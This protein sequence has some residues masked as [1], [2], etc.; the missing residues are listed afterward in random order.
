MFRVDETTEVIWRVPIIL[1]VLVYLNKTCFFEYLSYTHH[2]P[3]LAL[4]GYLLP[5]CL[6]DAALSLG[7]ALP[8]LAVDILRGSG[9]DSSLVLRQ[10]RG[11]NKRLIDELLLAENT[12]S[13]LVV[14]E[15]G[16]LEQ[17]GV[18]DGRR[19]LLIR[20]VYI[21]QSMQSSFS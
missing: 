3:P 16:E 21:S 20:L 17:K 4:G 14:S 6:P 12:T 13:S 2:V 18:E 19:R 1:L 15:L 9:L 8:C 10:I 11:L 5:Q 7:L